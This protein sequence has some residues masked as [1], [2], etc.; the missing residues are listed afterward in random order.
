[1]HFI[2]FNFVFFRFFFCNE[3]KLSGKNLLLFFLFSV[4]AQ[5]AKVV[6]RLREL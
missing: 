1:M 6:S 2:S 4:E 3:F 5:E